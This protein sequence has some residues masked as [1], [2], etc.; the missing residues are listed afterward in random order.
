MMRKITK[1]FIQGAETKTD[2]SEVV[3]LLSTKQDLIGIQQANQTL[4]T[5]TGDHQT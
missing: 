2:A 3:I 5:Q 4:E 1:H